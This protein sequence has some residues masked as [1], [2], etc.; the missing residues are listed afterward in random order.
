[1]APLK[2]NMIELA[3]TIT[4]LPL[5]KFVEGPWL[6]RRGDLYYLIYVSMGQGRETV[7]YAMSSSI[8]GPWQPMGEITGMADNSFTIHPGVVEFK[9]KWYFFYHNGN[10][11]LN[12]YK[13]SGGRRS[14]CVEEMSFNED[15]SI[16]FIAQ[17]AK[18]VSEQEDN[19]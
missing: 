4:V 12:G 10:L 18:G 9:G 16:K 8:K 1:M 15:G 14:V 3:D 5:P 6:T 2:D 13:G 17:T 19:Q 7:S 11:T